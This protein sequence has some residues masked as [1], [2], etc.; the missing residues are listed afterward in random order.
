MGPPPEWASEN[1]NSIRGNTMRKFAANVDSVFSNKANGSI[2]R[3]HIRFKNKTGNPLTIF[4]VNARDA[5]I[6]DA[7]SGKPL[8]SIPGLHDILIHYDG[9]TVDT[10]ISSEVQIVIE[11]ALVS[12]VRGGTTPLGRQRA[13]VTLVRSTSYTLQGSLL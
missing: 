11:G 12:G 3:F 1:P 13:T 5:Q 7:K 2:S 9:D 6:T 8:L 10:V 4:S